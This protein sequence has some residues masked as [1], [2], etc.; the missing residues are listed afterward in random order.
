MNDVE[1]Y[2]DHVCRSL[3]GSSSL[4]RHIRE[5]LREHLSEAI[6]R[7]VSAGLSREEASRKVIEE[8]GKPEMVRE[9]LEAVYGRSL[10]GLL[11][12]K[13]MDWKEITMKSGWKWSFVAHLMLA[14]VIAVE[15]ILISALVVA[16]FPRLVHEYE[17]LGR[18]SPEI[19]KSVFRW[20]RIL[21][22]TWYIWV[23]IIAAGWGIFEWKC[24]SENKSIIRMTFGTLGSLV[25]LLLVCL[26]S[27]SVVFSYYQLPG[28]TRMQ[29][30]ESVVLVEVTRADTSFSRLSRAVEEQDWE[31]ANNSTGTLLDVFLSL[32][33]MGSAA[34][35]LVG[36]ERRGEIDGIRRLIKRMVELSWH[37]HRGVIHESESQTK[38]YFNQLEET[39]GQLKA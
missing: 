2:L 29:Q 39:Y 12:E 36:L 18:Q 31:A 8:F 11:I 32:D 24:R 7:Q 1:H 26:V 14:M 5:E 3:S 33:H 4:R 25:M 13:A 34:P 27:L 22:D 16:V 21:V 35:T 9:G 15:V 6:E 20:I 38:H 30:T 19:F 23:A 37:V 28:L 17:I 10:V